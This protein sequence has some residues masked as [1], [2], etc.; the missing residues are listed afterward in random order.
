M[1]TEL[2]TR[3]KSEFDNMEVDLSY[4]LQAQKS[5]PKDF[6]NQARVRRRPI[7]LAAAVIAV[8]MLITTTVAV[9]HYTGSFERLLGIIGSER[10]ESLQP[11]GNLIDEIFTLD[12]FRVEIVAVGVDANVVDIYLTIEDLLESPSRLCESFRLATALGTSCHDPLLR[13]SVFQADYI[14]STADG[15]V[16]FHSRHVFLD[17]VSQQKLYFDFS[18]FI[19]NEGTR[20]FVPSYSVSFE[21]ELPDEI[22]ELLVADELELW[23]DCRNVIIE[24]VRVSPCTVVI[25]GFNFP[26]ED[27]DS[28]GF[29]L[30]STHG[31]SEYPHVRLNMI[32][33][34]AVEVVQGFWRMVGTAYEFEAHTFTFVEIMEIQAERIDLNDVVSIE[35]A[36]LVIPLR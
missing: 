35:I 34:S 7:S 31:V 10:A 22:S 24:Q 30:F 36:E 17:S 9:A 2:E 13:A 21:I 32:D 33:G 23:L 18:G 12:G 29:A 16:T 28:V 26:S 5:F 19:V 1:K 14:H 3:I 25:K 6:N 20:L 4:L 15:I 27:K 8:V 11:M